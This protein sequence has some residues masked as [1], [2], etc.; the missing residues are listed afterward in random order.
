M[1]RYEVLTSLT[2]KNYILFYISPIGDLSENEESL[3]LLSTW[4]AFHSLA[5]KNFVISSSSHTIVNVSKVYED[6]RWIK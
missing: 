5:Y 4:S 3:H 1:L 2:K 6:F